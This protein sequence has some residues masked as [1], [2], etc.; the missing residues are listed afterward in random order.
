MNKFDKLSTSIESTKSSQEKKGGGSKKDPRFLNYFE[1]DAEKNQS[2]MV[3][4]LPISDKGEIFFDYSIHSHSSRDVKNIQCSY[5][6]SRDSCPVCA[7][8]Y[9]A[10]Q[11]GDKEAQKLWNSNEKTLAQVVVVKSDI[12]IDVAP[13]GNMIKLMHVPYGIKKEIMKAID[14]GIVD[15]LSASNFVIKKAIGKNGYANYDNSFYNANSKED[16]PQ[17]FHDSYNSDQSYIYDITKEAPPAT[18]TAEMQE[19]LDV[20]EVAT[21][22]KSTVVTK[23]TPAQDMDQIMKQAAAGTGASQPD[24]TTTAVVEEVTTVPT[25]ASKTNSDDLLAMLNN[26]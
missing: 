25:P 18:T 26:R 11:A 12:D 19:W 13:D 21:V 16:I 10:Y 23:P 4:F 3:R 5:T 20:A 14:N 7:K 9:A 15:N 2:I 1:L 24:T 17:E 22:G 6:S 8:S